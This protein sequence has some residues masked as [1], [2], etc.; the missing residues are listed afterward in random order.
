MLKAAIL[1]GFAVSPGEEEGKPWRES[2]PGLSM[3]L[4]KGTRAAVTPLTLEEEKMPK[5]MPAAERHGQGCKLVN[6]SPKYLP[7]CWRLKKVSNVGYSKRRKKTNNKSHKKNPPLR[8]QHE[9]W[10]VETGQP[11]PQCP[12]RKG[13]G[14]G[15]KVCHG[16]P[17]MHLIDFHLLA[18]IQKTHKNIMEKSQRAHQSGR[19]AQI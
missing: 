19:L 10:C 16:A 8:Q 5:R 11:Q 9:N 4:V 18:K 15:G 7:S 17:K 14:C 13:P 1:Q 2:M 6:A 3:L 12:A